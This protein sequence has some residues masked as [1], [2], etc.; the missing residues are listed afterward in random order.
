MQVLKGTFKA[1]PLASLPRKFLVVLQFVVSVTLIIGTIVVFRQ[2]QFT[3]SRS[4]GYSRSG[5]VQIEMKSPD[6]HNHFDA[7]RSELLQS[8]AVSEV[9][10]SDSP[11]TGVMWDNQGIS[12]KGKDPDLQDDFGTVPVTPEFGKTIGW[13]IKEGRDLSRDSPSDSSA[14]I[15]NEAAVKFTGLKNLV[16]EMIK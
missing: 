14:V 9:A 5:L 7:F 3:K 2:V 1:G 15:P 8:G 10:E 11:V 13:K 4:V 16:G 12:W 6:I